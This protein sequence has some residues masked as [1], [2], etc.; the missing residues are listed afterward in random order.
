MIIFQLL[1]IGNY[2]ISSAIWNKEAR[3]NVSKTNKIARAR[4]A[5]ALTHEIHV[6]PS[7]I[8]NA[9]SIIFCQLR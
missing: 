4:R 5:T 6:L 9:V 3:V 7:Y 1:S 2:M 8:S